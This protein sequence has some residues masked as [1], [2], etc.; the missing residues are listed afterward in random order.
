[1]R[2]EWLIYRIVFPNGKSYIGLTKNLRNRISY[3]KSDYRKTN[4]PICNA[5]KHFGW[6]SIQFETLE[7]GIE[8][9]ERANEL[10]KEY[11]IKYNSLVKNGQGY[12][13]TEGGGGHAGRNLTP[14]EIEV[15]RQKSIE[16]WKDPVYRDKMI[17]LHKAKKGT[18][19]QETRNKMS[20]ITKE[21]LQREGHPSTGQKV[22]AETKAKQR[23]PRD[24]SG[25]GYRRGSLL[26]SKRI[27]CSR[28]DVVFFSLTDCAAFLGV[29]KDTL[30]KG[31]NHP[32][33]IKYKSLSY[34]K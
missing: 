29:S 31:I 32:N 20:R 5:I 26:K 11:I 17:Q 19:S 7:S 6:E 13:S 33:T 16:R 9:L 14:E 3:H 21:R 22:S 4:R 15:F 2:D 25:I 34:Y 30:H 18:Y 1:M 12:N 23:G 24:K 10:E 28:L 8:T 27:Y